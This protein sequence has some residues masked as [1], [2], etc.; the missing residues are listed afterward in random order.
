M[1]ILTA[2]THGEM[3]AT[4]LTNAHPYEP[5]REQ[6]SEI[7][8][9]AMSEIVHCGSDPS[10]R[11]LP[12]F[13][14][15]TGVNPPSADALERRPSG[16][17]R[18]GDMD[19]CIRRREGAVMWGLDA[20]CRLRARMLPGESRSLVRDH[21]A[22]SPTGG[23]TL[24]RLIGRRASGTRCAFQSKRKRLAASGG[25]PESGHG[26]RGQAAGR[27]QD[28][29]DLPPRLAHRPRSTSRV[30]ARMVSRLTY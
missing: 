18:G 12:H 27:V 28:E 30:R 3:N 10:T 2:A 9:T 17:A 24:N 5:W 25:R 21:S 19:S 13:I 14:A 1:P 15:K 26:Q 11:T 23:R 7:G 20:G 22:S 29:R 16:R 6:P 8:R 4:P